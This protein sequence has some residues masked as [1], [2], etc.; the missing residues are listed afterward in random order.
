MSF[1]TEPLRNENSDLVLG[2][3][4][5][6][7]VSGCGHG[8]LWAHIMV[9]LTIQ[10][11][12]PVSKGLIKYLQSTPLLL[13]VFGHYQQHPLHRASTDSNRWEPPHLLLLG[14]YCL[15]R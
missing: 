2:F 8:K 5:M 9:V 10:I 13:E 3:Y 4:H 1:S 12:A 7:N 6:E 14:S 11:V 15:L